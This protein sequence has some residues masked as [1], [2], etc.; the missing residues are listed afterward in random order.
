MAAILGFIL[1]PLCISI[2]RIHTK[3]PIIQK[4][5]R[6]PY[7]PSFSSL[8][9]SQIQSFS[10]TCSSN[11]NQNHTY[12]LSLLDKEDE[13]QDFEYEFEE[14]DSNDEEDD[15]GFENGEE[16]SPV[17][18]GMEVVEGNTEVKNV[19]LPNLTVKEKKESASYAHG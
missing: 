3:I 10:I 4:T 13:E 9:S 15:A 8:T 14:H 5:T 17:N 16:G 1:K 2:S 18:L 11:S 19:N 6:S 12:P 7:F